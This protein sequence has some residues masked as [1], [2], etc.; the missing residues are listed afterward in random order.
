MI[1]V[2]S[3]DWFK[4][5][6]E[7]VNIKTVSETSK[8]KNDFLIDFFLNKL[9][10]KYDEINFC[11]EKIS[12]KIESIFIKNWN[13]ETNFFELFCSFSIIVN[14]FEMFIK[15]FI[16]WISN[17]FTAI[18]GI[19]FFC[20]E[21]DF[22]TTDNFFFYISKRKSSVKIDFNRK[23]VIKRDELFIEMWKKDESEMFFTKKMLFE[24]MIVLNAN[25]F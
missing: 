15:V 7:N 5:V 12:D 11:Y 17:D 19:D 4:F 8:T 20:D 1:F 22:D 18:D 13:V 9:K 23:F 21:F 3:N 24:S 14:I 16:I 2:N 10:K 25:E 6:F